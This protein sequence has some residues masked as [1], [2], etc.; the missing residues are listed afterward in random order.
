MIDFLSKARE[1]LTQNH[2]DFINRKPPTE[3]PSNWRLDNSNF[4]SAVNSFPG[5]EQDIISHPNTQFV[6]SNNN[7]FYAGNLNPLSTRIVSKYVTIDSRFRDNFYSTAASDFSIQL[8]VR[9]NKVVSMQLSAIDLPMSFYS[10]SASYGNNFLY[11]YANQQYTEDEPVVE[12]EIIIIIPDGNYSGPDLISKINSLLCPIDENGNMIDPDSIFSYIKF[13]LDISEN[14]SGTGKVTIQ[15]VYN[16]TIGDSINCL[17]LDFTKNI[18]GIPD[19]VDISTKIGWNL[20]FIQ[21]KYCGLNS[22]I[23]DSVINPNSF[24]YIYLSIEDY[25]KNVNP[26]FLSAFQQTNLNDNILARVSLKTGSFTTL[27]ENDLNLLTESRIYFGPV[28]IQRLRIRLY[29]DYGRPLN[30]NNANY[31]F[32]LL[33]KM[34]YDL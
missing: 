1:L 16:T 11:I 19:N 23:S 21:K 3:I 9:L 20:G 15:P 29:D 14:G 24:K 25:Q 17:G 27:V 33:F 10:I 30:F 12:Y 4:P 6:F 32:V 26:L 18:N 31:S 22:Y 28:D 34:V 2:P 13:S 7:Q 5:R 8:P